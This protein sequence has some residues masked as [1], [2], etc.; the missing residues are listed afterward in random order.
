[1]HDSNISAQ[2][3]IAALEPTRIYWRNMSRRFEELDEMVSMI[4]ETPLFQHTYV[5]T[6]QNPNPTDMIY[7]VRS[8]TGLLANNL[9][10]LEEI[11]I[12]EKF[13]LSHYVNVGV[14][15][16]ARHLRT[17]FTTIPAS[18][19]VESARTIAFTH[20]FKV[21]GDDLIDPRPVLE[22]LI[23]SF[24]LPPEQKLS[25]FQAAMANTTLSSKS[26]VLH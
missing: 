7:D 15:F 24:D 3:L 17:R 20:I 21:I 13:Q 25:L 2:D 9:F 14:V 6:L 8:G 19:F 16:A 10:S 5:H 26:I 18:T 4:L 1:M 23:E 12:F 22:K 11:R